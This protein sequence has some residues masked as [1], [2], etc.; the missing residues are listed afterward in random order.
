MLWTRRPQRG[1][2]YIVYD[3]RNKKEFEG[4]MKA[5]INIVAVDTFGDLEQLQI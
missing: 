1:S 3:K 2:F 4:T 5:F